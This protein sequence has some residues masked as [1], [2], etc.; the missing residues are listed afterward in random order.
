MSNAEI[1]RDDVVFGAAQSCR[2]RGSSCGAEI[3]R[4]GGERFRVYKNTRTKILAPCGMAVFIIDTES[5]E[6]ST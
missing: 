3:A 5:G 1:T 6:A 4:A 2:R